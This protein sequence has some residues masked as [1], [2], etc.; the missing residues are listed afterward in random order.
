MQELYKDLNES[1]MQAVTATEG[2]IRVIAGAGTGKTKALTHRY[3]Y[4]INELGI[5]PSNILCITFT[6]KAANEMK[7]R[8]KA[9]LGE[10]FDT[11]FVATLHSFCTRILR[12][13]IT[14]LFYPDNFIVL[15]HV[16]QK[17]I[18]EEV[19]DELGIK[20]DTASFKFMIDQIRYYK[21][22]ITYVGYL[23][24]PNFDYNTLT[25]DRKTDEII[26]RYIK[27]QRKYF[28]LDFF[29][30]INFTIYLFEKY[31]DVL[32]KW[33]KRLCYI[34]VDE[35][36]DITAKEFK[37]IRRLSEYNRN[38]FVVGDPDQNIYEWRGAN[39]GVI[40]DFESWLN[41]PCFE[42]QLQL[43][44]QD[45]V[46]SRN[47]RS[48]S[49]ILQV[50]NSLIRKNRNRVEKDLYTQRD[51]GEAVQY[52]H[53]KNDKEEIK[54]I[55]ERIKNHKQNGGRYS[56]YAVLYRSNYVSR[57]VEQGFLAENIPYAVYGGVGFYERAEIKDVLSYMRLVDRTDDD[58]SF[59]R[60]INIPR[61]KIGK[62]KLQALKGYAE[63][64]G[65]SLYD[66][67]KALCDTELFKGCKAKSFVQAMEALRVCAD[68]ASVSELLQKILTV[69][70]YEL[71]IR[72]SGD[73]DR[74][75]NVTELL[76]S[77][78]TQETEF[79][80]PLT[81]STFLQ[82]ITLLRDSDVEDK[83]DCVKIMT[84]HTAKGLEFDHVCIV[85]LTEGIFPSARS[86]EER[87]NEALEEERRLMF[88]AVTRAKKTLCL[89][90]S[91]GFGVKGFSKVPSRFVSDIDASLLQVI[92]N[93]PDEIKAE[94]RLQ[95]KAFDK[96]ETEVYKVGDQIRHKVFGEGIVE[97]VDEQ[98]KTYHIRFVNGTKPI[99]FGYNG[100]SHVFK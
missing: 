59:L 54:F 97:Q 18:L 33:Q 21:N 9:M 92:G 51:G 43:R 91:E 67:L 66:A 44:A 34:M 57:F 6:N 56:D 5:S 17:K 86:L 11:S 65:T 80:E 32:L 14:K 42:N 94:Q 62:V 75:D 89:T 25:S 1:Q 77:I 35:F 58:L 64:N 60:I 37:L 12:E 81:L 95:T 49:P 10:E 31:P 16:D 38:L 68:E 45:I 84:V 26:F 19:Y 8:I 27:K 53:A 30:L 76:R 96:I 98:T 47:Y 3:A 48:A 13:E 52:L 50:A 69:T 7:K 15:D 83:S 28:G 61:R 74:L 63:Q 36:Q 55:C 78:V 85:G 87:K 22:L 4:L 72:E 41:N 90:E 29:D 93:V 99:S 40:V 82:N 20:M 88:V 73:I 23:S 100:L 39:M 71:Y 46:L 79:G 2:Y 70:G 24:D